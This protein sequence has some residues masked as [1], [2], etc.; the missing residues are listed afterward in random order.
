MSN[1][2]IT[3]LQDL[4]TLIN[5]LGYEDVVLFDSPSY[6]DA[7]I[8]IS[9]DN[10]AVYDYNKMVETLVKDGMTT[11]EAEVFIEYNTL[12]ALPYIPDSP[13]VIAQRFDTDI[14]S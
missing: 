8:G 4:K 3:T 10:R 14:P 7:C 13:I 11:K 1:R 9:E 6:V 5:S 2:K 12:R